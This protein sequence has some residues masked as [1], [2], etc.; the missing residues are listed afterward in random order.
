M[1]ARWPVGQ[2]PAAQPHGVA[3]SG[4]SQWQQVGPREWRVTC[5]APECAGCTYYLSTEASARRIQRA[6]ARGQ[7]YVGQDVQLLRP[8]TAVDWGAG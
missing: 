4:V 5:T 7:H 1:T 8:P 3:W 6:H 2:R